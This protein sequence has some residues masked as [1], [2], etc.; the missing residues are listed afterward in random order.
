MV[1]SNETPSASKEISSVLELHKKGA[2]LPD[3]MPQENK[4][5][6][7][8]I[9]DMISPALRG[10]GRKYNGVEFTKGLSLGR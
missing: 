6:L 4:A 5:R 10:G 2:T 3:E 7:K 9:N 8:E 1:S